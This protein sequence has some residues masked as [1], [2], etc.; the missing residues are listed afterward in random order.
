MYTKETQICPAYI[1]K[2]NSNNEKIIFLLTITNEKKKDDIILQQ[3]KLY[4]LLKRTTS[5]HLYDF[6]CLNCLHSFRA[7]NKLK[8]HEKVSKNDVSCGILM[9]QKD[10]ILE[11]KQNMKSGKIY[12]FC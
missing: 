5:K 7:G 3:K 11:F 10:N 8:S 1:S 9:P 12:Y 4:T 2:I 6:Y